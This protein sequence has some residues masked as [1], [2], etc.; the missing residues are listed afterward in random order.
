MALAVLS[1][2]EHDLFDSFADCM[3]PSKWRVE[4]LFLITF[5]SSRWFNTWHVAN[6][7]PSFSQHNQLLPL[8]HH[9]FYN[10]PA[11]KQKKIRVVKSWVSVFL[12]FCSLDLSPE[13][14]ERITKKAKHVIKPHGFITS[15]LNK[16]HPFCNLL[17]FPQITPLF[18]L[19]A[20]CGQW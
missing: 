17:P 10:K 9:C 18:V 12:P 13:A 16:V 7:K 6:D 3:V 4:S 5:H 8:L 20:L 14:W 2:P 1:I 11:S 19:W 15:I